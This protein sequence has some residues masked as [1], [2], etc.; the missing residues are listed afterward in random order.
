MLCFLGEVFFIPQFALPARK[1]AMIARLL[2][3]GLGIIVDRSHERTF[4]GKL[5]INLKKQ[6]EIDPYL[7]HFYPVYSIVAHLTSPYQQNS[8]VII[9][10]NIDLTFVPEG[11]EDKVQIEI[12]LQ[13]NDP[14]LFFA[15]KTFQNDYQILH[16]RHRMVLWI[17]KIYH[18][19]LYH[20]DYHPSTNQLVCHEANLDKLVGWPDE[21]FQVDEL[22]DSLFHPLHKKEYFQK[23]A[24]F[25]KLLEK[26]SGQ[27]LKEIGCNIDKKC[28]S[29][30][31]LLHFASRIENHRFLQSIIKKFHSVDLFDSK[32]MTPLHEACQ[33][34]NFETAKL[35]LEEGANPNLKILPTKQTCLMLAAM[36][37]KQCEKFI[38]LLLKYNAKTDDEDFY[39]MRA[40]DHAR[41]VNRQSCLLKLLHPMLSQI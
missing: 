15:W 6:N 7:A 35:L 26:T 41:Q 31:S 4:W 29:G 17:L 1:K 22:F 33:T 34:G 25:T 14:V 13:P 3:D 21:K 36:R 23:Q 12:L 2:K 16:L 30:K 37:K 39:G 24:D 10:F 5:K 9:S 38:K 19:N 28:P 40:V 27:Y 8:P 18:G 32:G 11:I 20:F